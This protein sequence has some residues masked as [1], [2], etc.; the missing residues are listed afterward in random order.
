MNYRVGTLD[1]QE[2]KQKI[3]EKEYEFLLQYDQLSVEKSAGRVLFE[4]EEA[5]IRFDPTYKFD[6]G[7]TQYD[8]S[9]KK[10]TPGWTDRIFWK[11]K[12]KDKISPKFYGKHDLLMSDHRPVSLVTEVEV[13]CIVDYKYREIRDHLAH[14][15]DQLKGKISERKDLNA[16]VNLSETKFNFGDVRYSVHYVKVLSISNPCS[17]TV[18]YQF[19]PKDD[20][21]Y[22]A[23]WLSI[24][25]KNGIIINGGTQEIKLTLHVDKQNALKLNSSSGDLSEKLLLHLTNGNTYEI[26]VNGNFLKTSFGNSIEELVCWYE[27][28]RTKNPK[29]Y[30]LVKKGELPKLKV[31]KELYF[32]CD[33]ISKYGMRDAGLFQESGNITEVNTIRDKIDSGESLEDYTGSIHSVCETLITFLDSL[34]EPVIPTSSFSQILDSYSNFQNSVDVIRKLNSSSHYNTFHYLTSFFRELLDNKDANNLTIDIIASGFSRLLLRS[35]QGRSTT[36]TKE[37]EKASIEFLKHFLKEKPLWTTES[38]K[39]SE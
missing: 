10:R 4:W 21:K 27:P 12:T 31:P 8:T 5:E 20:E 11:G 2:V 19:I 15:Y 7:T 33:Y 38:F 23:S 32:I 36:Q 18:E 17:F 3:K 39:N 1:D 13:K 22:C 9:E 25:S 30:D 29:K 34:Q 16:T 14:E 35:P 28:I 26:T 37:D 24:S 6:K